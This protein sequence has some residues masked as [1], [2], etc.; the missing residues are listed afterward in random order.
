[1][2]IVMD[3]NNYTWDKGGAPR[4]HPGARLCF[5]NIEIGGYPIEAV[6]RPA[7]ISDY[8]RWLQS[9]LRA[10]GEPTHDYDYSWDHAKMYYVTDP[11][12]AP[13][14]RGTK[15][16][17]AN[18]RNFI[19]PKQYNYSTYAHKF[20]VG[21]NLV[22]GWEKGKPVSNKEHRIPVYS[23]TVDKSINQKTAEKEYQKFVRQAK[24]WASRINPDAAYT[25]DE[26]LYLLDGLPDDFVVRGL[27]VT[28]N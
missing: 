1:M 7:V 21:H 14:L 2:I 5:D 13:D 19:I 25:V 22:F 17:G 9:F 11:R 8:N 26:V 20:D 10:G 27:R 3:Y 23:D 28:P 18:S 24:K 4:Q 6:G 16:C 15:M 12:T